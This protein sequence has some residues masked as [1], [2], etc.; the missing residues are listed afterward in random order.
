MLALAASLDQVSPHVL[1]EAIVRAARAR[2]L[3]LTMPQ[4]TAEIPGRGVRGTVGGQRVAVGNGHWTGAADDAAMG[5][6]APAGAASSTAHRRCSSPSTN[7]R[8]ER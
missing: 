4:D 7:G 8:P 3:P 1:A 6:S 2:H 5:A